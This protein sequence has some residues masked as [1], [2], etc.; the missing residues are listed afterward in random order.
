[1]NE[2]DDEVPPVHA[3]EETLRG[4]VGDE[5]G[6]QMGYDES[7]GGAVFWHG[8]DPAPVA[9]HPDAIRQRRMRLSWGWMARTIASTV[10]GALLI[11][12]ISLFSHRPT[13]PPAQASSAFDNPV[14]RALAAQADTVCQSVSR[15]V[16]TCVEWDGTRDQV[17]GYVGPNSFTFVFSYRNL[18]TGRRERTVLKIFSTVAVRNAWL[19]LAKEDRRHYPNLIYGERY[20]YYGTNKSRIK[21]YNNAIMPTPSNPTPTL[22]AHRHMFG[23]KGAL[24]L[25]SPAASHGIPEIAISASIALGWIPEAVTHGPIQPLPPLVR[26][27]ALAARDIILGTSPPIA[28]LPPDPDPLV[29]LPLSPSNPP[30]G[31][32]SLPPLPVPQSPEPLPVPDPVTSGPPLV[33]SPEP[34]ASP[35]GTPELTRTT[36]DSEA[37]TPTSSLTVP[38]SPTPTTTG[39]PTP[40]RAAFRRMPM[41]YFGYTPKD[42][43]IACSFSLDSCARK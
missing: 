1:L 10:I 14:F 26:T 22:I 3:F 36:T 32:P 17:Q 21:S 5:D 42:Q 16:A 15:L 34:T 37:P 19:V 39:I 38:P 13:A 8:R 27:L 20:A 40:D 12:A 11:S 41:T 43:R 6:L 35:V 28:G 18:R 2:D 9:A 7:S 24:V 29:P 23:R 25:Q 30:T 33:S 31:S 4:M